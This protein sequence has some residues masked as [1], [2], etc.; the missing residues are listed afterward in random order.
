MSGATAH[1]FRG[2]VRKGGRGRPGFQARRGVPSLFPFFC[3]SREALTAASHNSRRA[4]Q[5]P[6][7]FLFSWVVSVFLSRRQMMKL[8][9]DLHVTTENTLPLA[10]NTSV[11][12]CLSLAAVL[13]RLGVVF[14]FFFLPSSLV[15]FLA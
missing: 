8:V 10:D 15:F 12:S 7:C 3:P 13:A 6:L 4:K 9:S 11:F 5:V 14:F 2:P 1:L